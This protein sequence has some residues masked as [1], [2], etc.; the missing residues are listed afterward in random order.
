[1]INPDFKANHISDLSKAIGI[2]IPENLEINMNE[3]IKN[4]ILE[5]RDEISD[6]SVYATG[7]KKL[8]A[9]LDKL[10]EKYKMMKFDVQNFNETD[11]VILKDV[12][13]L[14]EEIDVILTKIVSMSS[15][16]FAK[17][18]QKDI[19][20]IW[21]NISKAQD[22]ID[23]WLKTQKLLTQLH[24]IFSYGDLKKQLSEEYPK[25][26]NVEKQWRQIMEQVKGSPQLSEVVQMT[27]IKENFMKWAS[28][29]EDVNQSLN[30]YLNMKRDVFPRFYFVSNEELTLML[31]QSGDPEI[32]ASRYIQQVFEGMK[33]L[34]LVT[35]D[36]EVLSTNYETG[37]EEKK[38]YNLKKITHFVSEKG[39]KVKF[40]QEINPNE[41]IKNK[42]EVYY[43][44]VLLEKWLTDVEFSMKLTLKNLFKDCYFDLV[45]PK[46]NKSPLRID[47]AARHIEQAVLCISQLDWTERVNDAIVNMKSN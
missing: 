45:K 24:Q 15:S 6:R 35:N 28:V 46:D 32:I 19:H 38:I 26:Q 22:I 8:N 27:K 2:Y 16:K 31:A 10:K 34:D 37:Q 23:A 39:E 4:G 12:E 14:S 13:P 3:L 25:Y 1:L 30:Q 11:L 29:L 36:V 5:K 47:W 33:K 20:F 21:G 43:R 40:L 9:T 7:Q 18:L 41:E 42:E 17:Y 44:T